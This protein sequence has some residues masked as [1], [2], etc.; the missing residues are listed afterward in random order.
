[1]RAPRAEGRGQGKRAESNE[2]EQRAESRGQRAESREQRA[3]S[4]GGK[5]SAW[6]ERTRDEHEGKGKKAKEQED[7]HEVELN[8]VTHGEITERTS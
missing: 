8:R 1:L 4:K 6:R 2:I 5:G 7:K 3:E